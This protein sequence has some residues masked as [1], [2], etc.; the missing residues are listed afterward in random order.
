M[1][2]DSDNSLARPLED[3]FKGDK[4][5]DVN[6]TDEVVTHDNTTATD[7]NSHNNVTTHDNTTATSGCSS[8]HEV[9]NVSAWLW[10]YMMECMIR[11]IVDY[12]MI[13]L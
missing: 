8:L 4:R 2:E 5:V 12:Y 13:L 9:T 1:L 10:N 3:S 11:H 7:D 6:Q